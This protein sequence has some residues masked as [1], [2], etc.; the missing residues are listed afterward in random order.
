MNETALFHGVY[1]VV[2]VP[3][4]KDESLDLRG[5]VHLV[6]Y[7][8]REGCH[9]L[10][11]LG[12]GGESP[13]FTIDEKVDI[14][15]TAS[16][17][18]QKR[19]PVIAGCTFVSLAETV[20]FIK[21]TQSIDIDGYL[22]ALPT[23][24]PLAFED[25]YA[26]YSRIVQLTHKKILYY[27]FPQITG[28][29]FT[30]GEMERLYTISGIDG[31]KESSICLR[32]IKQHLKCVSG[33]PFSLFSGASQL[34]LATLKSGGSG[35]MCSIP[36]VAPRLVVECYNSWISG[37][38]N[39]AQQYEDEIFTHIGL[40]NNFGIPASIQRKGFKLISRLP[41]RTGVGRNPR[42]AVF[43]ETLRQLGHPITATVRSPLPQISDK[44]RAGVAALIKKS[45]FLSCKHCAL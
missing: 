26:F 23:Y 33:R 27:H 1:P 25:V 37:D 3:L 41:F 17:R 14:L 36:S 11:V 22:V 12:S 45:K 10:L 2:P 21:S 6:D 13:Y 39:R 34:L 7:Y 30:P 38:K 42:Q 15:K 32:E 31:A 5:F 19:I 44:D 4:Q 28:L 24:Y 16:E 8:I 35:T 40:M 43:K 20:Q 29:S 18:V 9:G